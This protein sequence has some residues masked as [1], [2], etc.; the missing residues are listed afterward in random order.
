MVVASN[1]ICYALAGTI[2]LSNVVKPAS[3]PLITRNYTINAASNDSSLGSPID[4]DPLARTQIMRITQEDTRVPLG[5]YTHLWLSFVREKWEMTDKLDDRGTYEDP[6]INGYRIEWVSERS[7]VFRSPILAWVALKIIR[8]HLFVE[9]EHLDWAEPSTYEVSERWGDDWFSLVPVKV[10]KIWAIIDT[11]PSLGSNESSIANET[12]PTAMDSVQTSRR[13]LIAR[14]SSNDSYD[15]KVEDLGMHE[16]RLQL[17]FTSLTDSFVIVYAY[18]CAVIVAFLKQWILL[19]KF[20]RK[21]SEVYQAGFVMQTSFANAKI[22]VT[23]LE[24]ES[25]GKKPSF[26]NLEQVLR[27]LLLYSNLQRQTH[28]RVFDMQPCFVDNRGEREKPF[29]LIQLV[30]QVA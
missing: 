16:S 25:Y 28:T 12:M 19:Y 4:K 1:L 8:K 2:S 22:R 7:S 11:V 23:L 20:T 9:V 30:N 18:F 10:G 15:N 29:A 14:H 5:R 13:A 24:I 3:L 17:I 6:Q 26:G 27:S 21:I